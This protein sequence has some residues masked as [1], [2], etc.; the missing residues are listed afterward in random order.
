MIKHVRIVNIGTGWVVSL[1]RTNFFKV[2][3]SL[4]AKT[5]PWLRRWRGL[6]VLVVI[7]QEDGRA[8]PLTAAVDLGPA[9]LLVTD[10]DPAVTTRVGW[11][12]SDTLA[13]SGPSRQ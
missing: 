3:V 7:S 10:T 5:F 12:G 11:A 4:L 13:L 6:P 9:V 2:A 8:V 1:M